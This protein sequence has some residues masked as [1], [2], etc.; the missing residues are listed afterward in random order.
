MLMHPQTASAE[1]FNSLTET[2]LKTNMA[3]IWA[4]YSTGI[5]TTVTWSR[6]KN[7]N[8]VLC[9]GEMYYEKQMNRLTID[10]LSIW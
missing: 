5:K 9:D 4:D 8:N 6:N 7:T 10:L 1:L 3:A 2:Y